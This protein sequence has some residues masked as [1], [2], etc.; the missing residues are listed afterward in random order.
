MGAPAGNTNATKNKPYADALKRVLAQ[1]EVKD[2]NGRV[3]VP[4]GEALRA[5]VEAQVTAALKGDSMAQKEVADRLDGKS[6]QQIQLQGDADHPLTV[7]IVRFA[8][9]T[10]PK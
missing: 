10:P 5:I 2:E 1:L 7:E 3:I 8:P 6:A 4:A 9:D